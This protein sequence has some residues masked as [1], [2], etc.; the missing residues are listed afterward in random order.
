ME[1]SQKADQPPAPQTPAAYE[2]RF[3]TS[4]EKVATRTQ[5]MAE[6]EEEEEGV[7]VVKPD[8]THKLMKTGRCRRSDVGETEDK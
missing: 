4:Q 1:Y 3:V 6:E 7:V 2:G 5:P 8:V